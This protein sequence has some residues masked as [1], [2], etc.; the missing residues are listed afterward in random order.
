M[1]KL[2]KKLRN[3]EAAEAVEMLLLIPILVSF[4]FVIVDVSLYF[5]VRA[6]V[7]DMARDA[8][9]QVAVQGGNYSPLNT[10]SRTI[11]QQTYAALINE[12]GGCSVGVCTDLPE[13]SCTP[14]IVR[15]LGADVSCT[16]TYYH[17]PLTA[18]IFGMTGFL[19]EFEVTQHA[20][21]E[22]YF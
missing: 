21:S 4:I 19:N 9:R 16:I 2:L 3:E 17:K 8:A 14:N 6:T 18:D 13:V 1:K 5:N 20:R 10:Q 11:A 12:E 7:S 22:T 15:T